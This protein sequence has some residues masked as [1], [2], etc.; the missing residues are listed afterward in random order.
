[1]RAAG[2]HRR[3]ER[4]AGALPALLDELLKE[5]RTASISVRLGDDHITLRV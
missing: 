1:M 2:P 4:G 3:F 5:R